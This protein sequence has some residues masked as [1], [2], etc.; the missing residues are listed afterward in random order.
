MTPEEA[1][2]I[3]EENN[4]L[5]AEINDFLLNE[6]IDPFKEDNKLAYD[7]LFELL[8]RLEYEKYK[9]FF[10]QLLRSYENF[11]K[12]GA[13]VRDFLGSKEAEPYRKYA[14]IFDRFYSDLFLVFADKDLK[15]YLLKLIE[16]WSGRDK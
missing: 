1:K 12:T 3:G 4:R 8:K 9:I 5:N 10:F 16:K 11:E 13:E 7:F 14:G 15:E 2:K 6:G